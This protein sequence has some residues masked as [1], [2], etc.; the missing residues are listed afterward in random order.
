[1]G[2]REL[3]QRI[4]YSLCNLYMI[5]MDKPVTGLTLLKFLTAIYIRRALHISASALALY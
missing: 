1:M 5:M 4:V 3:F 2:I